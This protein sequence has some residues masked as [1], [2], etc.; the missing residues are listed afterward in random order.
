MILTA[1]TI[2]IIRWEI[3][4]WVRYSHRGYRSCTDRL[5]SNHTW[6]GLWD[7]WL[8]WSC[9]IWWC[10]ILINMRWRCSWWSSS[11]G[12]LM[13][14]RN[15]WNLRRWKVLFGLGHLGRVGFRLFMAKIVTYQS[16]RLRI[17]KNDR[18]W[19]YSFFYLLICNC[20]FHE[21]VYNVVNMIIL[22]ICPYLWR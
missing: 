13:V 8:G 20:C 1:R 7:L 21:F 14:S 2:I 15:I 18:L 19:K 12:R 3:I 6:L 22:F 9:V 16:S 10:M 4:R 11:F 5:C 17:D